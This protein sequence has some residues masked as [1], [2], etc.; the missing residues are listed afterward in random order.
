MTNYSKLQNLTKNDINIINNDIFIK[1]VKSGGPFIDI[2]LAKIAGSIMTI[3]KQ[4]FYT[5]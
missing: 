4:Y 1:D 2:F 3:K 5:F